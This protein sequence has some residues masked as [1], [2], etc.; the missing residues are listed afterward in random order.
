MPELKPTREID[1]QIK[2][3]INKSLYDNGKITKE[4]HDKARERI[5]SS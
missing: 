5:L 1:I 2:L 4:M 3:Q